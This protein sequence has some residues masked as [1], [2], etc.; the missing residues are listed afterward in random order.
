MTLVI[1]PAGVV[2][3]PTDEL[4][5]WAFGKHGHVYQI[6]NAQYFGGWDDKTRN[7][8]NRHCVALVPTKSGN[9]YWLVSNLGETYAYAM[10]HR[11]AIIKAS[12]AQAS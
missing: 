2:R 6:G 12:G 1:D 10:H 5:G 8:P 7:D 4:S 3:H 9:G 11:L